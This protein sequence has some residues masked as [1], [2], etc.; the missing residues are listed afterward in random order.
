M[1]D[2]LR[3][4]LLICAQSSVETPLQLDGSAVTWAL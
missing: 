2:V 3:S 1:H 4:E